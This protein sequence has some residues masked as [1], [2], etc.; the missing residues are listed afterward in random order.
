MEDKIFKLIHEKTK[1]LILTLLA[2]SDKNFFTFTEIKKSLSLTSGNLS[3]QL[4][5]LEEANLIII[6]KR[7]NKNKTLSKISITPFGIKSLKQ[8]F[9]EMENVINKFKGNI[10]K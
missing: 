1:F 10:K 4:K 3:I 7:L 8:Y 2:T 5:K 6:D 9:E